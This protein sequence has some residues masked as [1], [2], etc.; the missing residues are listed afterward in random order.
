MNI[1]LTGSLG[2]IGKPLAT[3]LVQ[4]GHQ[5]TVISSSADRQQEIESLGASAAIGSIEDVDFLTTAFTGADAVFCMVPPAGFIDADRV[6]FYSRIAHNY[7]KAIT[8]SGVRRVVHL[9]TFGADLPAGTG[10]LVGAH[11]A[12]NILN[13]LKGIDITHVRPTYFYYNLNTFIGMIKNAGVMVSNYGAEDKILLVSPLD[14]A[15]V[16]AEELVKTS[17]DSVRY[18]ASDVRSANEIASVIGAAIGKPDLKWNVISSE[19]ALKAMLSHGM[20]EILAK[21]MVE[22][23]DSQHNGTLAADFYRVERTPKGKVK[24]E[25]AVKD[26]VV[27]YNKQ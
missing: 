10:I 25:D 16:V 6:A 4:Q 12:E 1:T 11:R 17:S 27:A 14:I 20:P 7:A 26:F 5:V 23:F 9:S 8:A 2:H 19:E 21:G 15:D 3:T 24:L 13:E 18:I 22:M